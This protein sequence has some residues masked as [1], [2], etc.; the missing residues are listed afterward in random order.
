MKLTIEQEDID[1]ANAV[2]NPRLVDSATIC[3][4]AQALMRLGYEEVEVTG[5]GVATVRG[6]H[7]LVFGLV[8]MRDWDM[9]GPVY[10]VT[11][12]LEEVM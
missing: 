1:A 3:P 6:H 4:I 2:R 8:W 12:E 7:W 10:P 9:G 11:L 5:R